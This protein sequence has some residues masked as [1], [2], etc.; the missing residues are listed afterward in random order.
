MGLE[1]FTCLVIIYEYI[2]YLND[3]KIKR[4]SCIYNENT[5]FPKINIIL[6]NVLN[7]MI[8]IF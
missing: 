4:S 2:F 3:C 1:G 7:E 8:R 6:K 5:S